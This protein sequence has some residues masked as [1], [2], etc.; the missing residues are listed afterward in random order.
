LTKILFETLLAGL[1]LWKSKEAR[2]YVDRII[3]LKKDWYEEF[4]RESPDDNVL[5][6]I[7]SELS[8]ISQAFVDQAG[9]KNSSSK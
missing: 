5:D 9:V 7:D 1:S 2:K 3:K 6:S 8:I 4:N